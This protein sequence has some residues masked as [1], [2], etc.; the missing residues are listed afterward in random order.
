LFPSLKDA[1]CFRVRP[2]TTVV[3]YAALACALLAGCAVAPEIPVINRFAQPQVVTETVYVP[4]YVEVEKAMVAPP[5]APTPEPV[6]LPEEHDQALALLLELARVSNGNVEEARKELAAAQ[7]QFTK[8]RSPQNRVR[9]AMYSALAANTTPDDTRLQAVLEPLVA[10]LGGLPST[11]PM[12]PV[13]EM[14]LAQIN[15]RNRQVREA[16]KK[17]DELQ[18]KLDALK[19]IEKQILDRDRRRN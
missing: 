5:P 2:P 1:S 12:R 3:A 14:L 11:H 13:A 15:E 8:E 9:V 18:Q 10:K 16:N 7:A 4:I 17:V 19:A 6:K